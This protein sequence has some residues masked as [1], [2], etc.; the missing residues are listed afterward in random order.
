M[1]TASGFVE[2][3]RAVDLFS[4]FMPVETAA[5]LAITARNAGELENR[6]NELHLTGKQS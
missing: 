2:A 3:L 6:K 5:S 4:K 1:S